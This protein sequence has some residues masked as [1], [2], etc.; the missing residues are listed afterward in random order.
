[1]LDQFYKITR[2]R[3]ET[4]SFLFVIRYVVEQ[5]NLLNANNTV[6]LIIY[7]LVAKKEK[8]T[9]FKYVVGVLDMCV[10]WK[11]VLLKKEL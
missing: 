5:K 10:L 7:I 3:L 8:K 9:M 4:L 11:N 2:M 1:M 6:I